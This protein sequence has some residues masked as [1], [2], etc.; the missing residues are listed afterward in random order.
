MRVPSMRP[1]ALLLPL[2][3]F[4]LV[5]PRG[6]SAQECEHGAQRTATVS[7]A[8]VQR[9]HVIAGSGSLEIRGRPGLSDARASGRACASDAG[10]LAEID[11]RVR[12]SGSTA[13][14]EVLYPEDRMHFGNRYAYLDLEVEV[15]QGVAVRVDDGSGTMSLAGTGPAELNDGSGDLSARDIGGRLDIEDGSGGIL[16]ARV[17]GAV[18]IRDGSGDIEIADVRG[19]VDVEDGSGS[20]RID[21]VGGSV[22]L[23]DGS[24][25]MRVAEVVDDVIVEDGSGSIHVRG[26]GGDFRVDDDGSGNVSYADVRGRVAVPE[27]D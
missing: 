7:M 16:V 25:D 15:P 12:R 27:Y 17:S 22:R 3:L 24:G 14:I 20:M 26:V 10:D 18:R 9:V 8:G 5:L 13:E 21:G 1:I 23:S 4:C 6:A 2:L 11:I 19:S